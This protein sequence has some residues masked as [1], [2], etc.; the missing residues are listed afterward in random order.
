MDPDANIQEQNRIRARMRE[1]RAA[2]RRVSADDRGRLRE[3]REA[4]TDWL[5]AGGFRPAGLRPE[6]AK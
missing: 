5:Y 1:A 4:L 3:L 6:H 2:K